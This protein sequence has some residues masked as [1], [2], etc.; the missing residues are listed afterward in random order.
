MQTE[1]KMGL[2]CWAIGGPFFAPDGRAVGWGEVDDAV[3]RRAIAAAVANGITLFDT[4]QAYGTGHSEEVLGQALSKHPDVQIVT[5]VGLG[6]D[7][8]TQHIT[9]AITDP[10]AIRTSLADSRRRLRRDRID[11]V[12]LHLNELPPDEAAPIFEALEAETSSGTLGHYG[13]STDFPNHASAFSDRAGFVAVEFA[14]N[15]FFRATAMTDA[16]TDEGLLPLIRS[17]LAMGVLGGR[18]DAGHRFGDDDVRGTDEDWKTYFKGGRISPTH[19]AQLE[20]VREILRSDGRSLAQ[21]ALGWIWGRNPAAV[22]IPGFR[23][24]EQVE[25]L[26]GALAHGALPPAA[27]DEIER[28]IERAPEGPPRAR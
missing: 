18:Y 1:P 16:A 10:T 17:P 15:I 3:S 2:G 14:M 25:D 28:L 8:S 23:T 12:L 26:C 5:K 24:P 27:M 6:I 19:L 7:P 4:A 9:C 11:V 13:W 21:G 22:P 20:A